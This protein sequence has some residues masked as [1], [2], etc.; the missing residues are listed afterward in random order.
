VA[1]AEWFSL[2]CRLAKVN[3]NTCT[4]NLSM[5]F[6]VDTRSS[7]WTT[8]AHQ[9]LD[10]LLITWETVEPELPPGVYAIWPRVDARI[11]SI[12]VIGMLLQLEHTISDVLLQTRLRAVLDADPPHLILDDSP[13]PA[14]EVAVHYM[15]ALIKANGLR[16]SFAKWVKENRRFEGAVITRVLNGLPKAIQPFVERDGKGMPP[17]LKIELLRAAQ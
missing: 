6:N 1:E 13:F 3:Q 9:A 8:R 7:E 5:T 12:E 17:R 15:N 14:Q 4:F 16:V 11:A 2:V 10:H